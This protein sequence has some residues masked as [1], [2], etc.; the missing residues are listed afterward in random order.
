VKSLAVSAVVLSIIGIAAL[1]EA[2]ATATT[3]T[4][5]SP[6]TVKFEGSAG[7]G[8]TTRVNSALAEAG[9]HVASP[10]EGRV[11]RWRLA[12]AGIWTAGTGF[13]L[14]V[15]RPSGSAEYTKVAA[16]A[17]AAPI[18]SA[19]ATDLPI[20]AGDL[21]GLDFPEGSKV[22][23]AVVPGSAQ[24][25]WVPLLELG[26]TAPPTQVFPNFEMGFNADVA[27]RPGIAA[28]TQSSGSISGG[29]PV[30]ILGHDFGGPVT[31]SFG[32]SVAASTVQAE[33]LILAVAPPSAT[34]GTVDV[35]VTAEGGTTPPVDAARF[36]YTACVVPKLRGLKL[37]ASRRKLK[38]A[39]CG[40]G[41]VRRGKRRAAK[42]GKR[43]R[44]AAK[45][46]KQNPKPGTVLPPGGRVSV[47]LGN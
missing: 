35:S 38:A 46:R 28:L 27:P 31:V 21:V 10:V 22:G 20:E 30:A 41:K 44:R 24:I 23:Q 47:R 36:T 11:V 3:V 9:A 4:V 8:P 37:K 16:S 43:Q 32:A 2:P 1:G 39:S 13:Q 33:N 42:N 6:L 40:L 19:A 17:P 34:P 15:L 25:Y 45:V 26:S 14:V 18:G 7:L 5:G 29:T 12:E